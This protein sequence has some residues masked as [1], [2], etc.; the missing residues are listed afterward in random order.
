MKIKWFGQA[1]EPW[2]IGG[3]VECYK[4]LCIFGLFGI[5]AGAVV[6]IVLTSFVFFVCKKCFKN[7]FTDTTSIAC[8]TASIL[9]VRFILSMLMN[10][11]IVIEGLFSPI[12]ILSDGVCGYAAIFVLVGLLLSK[13]EGGTSNGTDKNK[14]ITDMSHQTIVS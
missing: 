4:L 3:D 11:G 2:L 10:F 6:F 7:I 8:A 5:V 13:T 12:P 1:V 9:L 14:R